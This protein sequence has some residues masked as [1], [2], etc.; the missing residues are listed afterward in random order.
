MPESSI[1]PVLNSTRRSFGLNFIIHLKR[2]VV[3]EGSNELDAHHW[4]VLLIVRRSGEVSIRIVVKSNE[5]FQIL[6]MSS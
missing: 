6:Q 2:I 4:L 5:L 1:M 3:S